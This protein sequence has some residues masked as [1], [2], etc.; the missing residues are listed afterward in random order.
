VWKSVRG[1]ENAMYHDPQHLYRLI[2]DRKID[3]FVATE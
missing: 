2:F 1:G 3:D